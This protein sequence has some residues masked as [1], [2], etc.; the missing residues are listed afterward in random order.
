MG[1]FFLPDINKFECLY[2]VCISF[3]LK[4]FIFIIFAYKYDF[5]LLPFYEFISY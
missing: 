4:N 1:P 5:V 2:V 3:H